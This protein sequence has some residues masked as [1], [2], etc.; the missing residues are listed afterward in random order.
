MEQYSEYQRLMCPICGSPPRISNP[1]GTEW[2]VFCSGNGTHVSQG[3]WKLSELKAWQDWARRRIDKNQP[4]FWYMSNWN[5]LFGSSAAKVSDFLRRVQS[6]EF[7][8]PDGLTWEEWLKYPHDG[9]FP[10]GY[11]AG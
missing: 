9:K 8:L 6:G 11:P 4:D 2:K 3:D 5:K 7:Q 1:L 10:V